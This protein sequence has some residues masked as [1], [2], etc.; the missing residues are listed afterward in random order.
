MANYLVRILGASTALLALAMPLQANV[1]WQSSGFSEHNTFEDRT[2]VTPTRAPARNVNLS[3]LP[4]DI[5]SRAA[6]VADAR[7]GEV[8]YGKNSNEI[9]PIASITKLM[10]AM[11]VLDAGQ[12]MNEMLRIT[13]ADIDRLRNSRSRLNVGTELSRAD[14]MLLMLMSSENRAASA[15][16]RNYPGGFNAAMAAMN[17]KTRTLGMTNSHFMDSSGLH[18]ENRSTPADLIKMVQAA[19]NYSQ[20]RTYSTLP[21]YHVVLGNSDTILTY[22][23]TNHQLVSSDNWDIGISKTGFINEAG[24]CLVMFAKVTDTPV[25]IVLMDSPNNSVRTTDANR[26][27]NWLE[28]SLSNRNYRPGS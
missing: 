18:G 17:K 28:V 8:L 12:D 27:R 20:I 25:I 26:V 16:A 2:F 1:I 7:T 21:E 5:S 23:N 14:M 4:L 10:T 22:R 6:I 19:Y 24:R 15:L 9:V 13:D 11:I 3:S